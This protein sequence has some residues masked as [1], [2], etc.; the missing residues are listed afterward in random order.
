MNILNIN[1][2]YYT[3][4]LYKPMEDSLIDIGL[5]IETYVPVYKNHHI[6]DEINFQIPKHVNTSICYKKYDR[7]FFHLKHLK[8]KK[9]VFK[10]YEFSKY[11]IIHAHSLFSNGYIAYMINSNS[12]YHI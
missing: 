2:Y 5:N 7:Y 10:K 1:S 4:S 6:R 11:D 8:I 12:E 3:S 9:D